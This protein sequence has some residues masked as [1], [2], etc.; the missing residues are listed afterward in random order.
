M[1]LSWLPADAPSEAPPS[2][3]PPPALAPGPSA[4]VPSTVSP[5]D[6]NGSSSESGRPGRHAPLCAL[7]FLRQ[8]SH[9][10]G[11]ATRISVGVCNARLYHVTVTI[12]NQQC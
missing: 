4:G 11:S 2:E 6:G 5:G 7:P 12:I 3:S 9:S 8:R 1:F 10:T